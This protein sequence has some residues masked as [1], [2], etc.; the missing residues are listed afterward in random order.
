[1]CNHGIDDVTLLLFSRVPV[2]PVCLLC[3]CPSVNKSW[4]IVEHNR[5][6]R[7]RVTGSSVEQP[8]IGDVKYVNASWDEVTAVANSSRYCEQWIEF[9]CYKSRLLNT[10]REYRSGRS[11]HRR[12]RGRIVSTSDVSLANRRRFVLPFRRQTLHLL[13]RSSQ[14]ESRV[15][16]R[17]FPRERQVWL[18]R[19]S[20]LHRLQVLVQL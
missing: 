12:P 3:V 11:N 4:T 14:S 6:Y 9:S 2:S 17:I 8:Y 5:M 1:M 15:L 18:C 10:P 20:N 13:D 7:T 16:G 19:Q